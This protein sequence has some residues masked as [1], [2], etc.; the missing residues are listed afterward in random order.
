ML[1]KLTNE[2]ILREKYIS[3]KVKIIDN[4]RSKE[5][6]YN[7][8]IIKYNNGTSKNNKTIRWYNKSTI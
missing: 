5:D 1:K 2:E 6:L 4:L 8:N 7:N 3:P